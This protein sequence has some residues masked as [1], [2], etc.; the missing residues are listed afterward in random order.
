MATRAP[1]GRL[2]WILTRGVSESNVRCPSLPLQSG[3]PPFPPLLAPP[4]Y[5]TA[6][7][8]QHMTCSHSI[9]QQKQVAAYCTYQYLLTRG[10]DRVDMRGTG[11]S[12]VR[13]GSTAA[14]L[15]ALSWRRMLVEINP[16]CDGH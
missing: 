5:Q 14:V 10:P 13:G 16:R 8:F 1:F 2:A 6:S 3:L 12:P 7:R 9:S 4:E 11:Y 15:L